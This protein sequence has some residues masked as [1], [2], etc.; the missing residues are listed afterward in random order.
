MSTRQTVDVK[1]LRH[2]D[3]LLIN[4]I[5][6]PGQL[7]GAQVLVWRRGDLS[8][9][10]WAGYRDLERGLP[11]E[12]DTIFRIYSMT[13]PIVSVAL[14]ML[15]E[16]GRFRLDTPASEFIPKFADL[17]VFAGVDGQTGEMQTEERKKPVTIHQLLTHTSGLTYEMHAE[18]HPV[19]KLYKQSSA[20]RAPLSLEGMVD[21]LLN[22]PLAYQ[23]GTR[24]HYSVSTD[25]C[26]RLVEIISGQPID[27]FLQER[28][29][30]PLG[31]RDTGYHVPPQELSR[32]AELYSIADCFDPNLT[33]ENLEKAWQ[34]GGQLQPLNSFEPEI[35]KAPHNCLRGGHGLVSTALDYLKFAR[36]LL[37]YG[38]WEGERLLSHKT[39]E[40]MRVNH[41]STDFFPLEIRNNPL[42][43]EGWGLGVSVNMDPAQSMSLGSQG[44]YGWAGLASTKFLIDPQEELILIQMGQLIPPPEH[45]FFQYLRNAVYQ[46]LTP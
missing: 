5:G 27:R 23:P 3:N 18:Q 42:K 29:F 16:E 38:K 14:L 17:E 36:M 25:V 9:F 2:L 32:L 34:S 40:L 12:E 6:K 31:M 41:L 13:K 10:R 35:Y 11:I 45:L 44:S 39:V 15:L 30:G 19:A 24:W 22:F 21:H 20:E 7:P 8:Y 26:A 37:Q 43:G 33:P 28:I 4:T 46:A 1:R